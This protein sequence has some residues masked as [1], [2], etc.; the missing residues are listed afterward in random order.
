VSDV[1]NVSQFLEQL[2][3]VAANNNILIDYE[4]QVKMG[5]DIFFGDIFDIF[6][7]S[8]FNYDMAHFL[9]PKL[10]EAWTVEFN[11]DLAW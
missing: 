8:M 7:V 6:K 2:S 5:S 4:L 10:G 3:R 11:Q 1:L 9:M